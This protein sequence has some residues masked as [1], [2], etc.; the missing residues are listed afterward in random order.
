MKYEV[1]IQNTFW[2][3]QLYL[4]FLYSELALIGSK[5]ILTWSPVDLHE[6]RVS[7]VGVDLLFSGVT[8][9]GIYLMAT[10]FLLLEG[11]GGHYF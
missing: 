7:R 8:T 2:H 4:P 6:Q 1:T 10:I 5:V 9:F 3:K 11:G